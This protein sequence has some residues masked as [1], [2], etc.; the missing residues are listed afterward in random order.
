MPDKLE[1]RMT[2]LYKN[3]DIAAAI[4][5]PV[6]TLCIQEDAVN[7]TATYW[8]PAQQCNNNVTT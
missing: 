3:T 6:R 7:I 8:Y 5:H 1:S 2:F 4:Q